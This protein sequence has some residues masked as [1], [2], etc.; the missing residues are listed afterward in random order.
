MTRVST[1]TSTPTPHLPGA[2]GHLLGEARVGRWG[3]GHQEKSWVQLVLS[4]LSPHP[5]CSLTSRNFFH[6]FPQFPHESR[7]H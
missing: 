7:T 6:H 1:P 3:R 4:L 2:L 5:S